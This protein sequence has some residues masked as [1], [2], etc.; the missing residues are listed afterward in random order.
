MTD[1]KR[2]LLALKRKDDSITILEFES[3]HYLNGKWEAAQE[4]GLWAMIP[5][6]EDLDSKEFEDARF[7]DMRDPVACKIFYLDQWIH[8]LQKKSA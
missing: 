6:D 8:I 4:L 1:S 2:Y 7:F 3:Q 5:S